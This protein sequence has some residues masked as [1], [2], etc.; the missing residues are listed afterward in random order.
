MCIQIHCAFISGLKREVSSED[1]ENLNG[2]TKE[3][4]DEDDEQPPSPAVKP[5]VKVHLTPFELEGLWSLLGKLESLP[6][7][8]KCVPAGIH[9]AAALLHDIR[10]SIPLNVSVTAF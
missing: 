9:N 7:H 3:E 1:G 5:G 10:V 6:S 4:D 2:H 8:K